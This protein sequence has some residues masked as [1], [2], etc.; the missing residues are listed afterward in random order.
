MRIP[1]ACLLDKD[2]L[3]HRYHG[4]RLLYLLALADALAVSPLFSKLALS[5][6]HGD[7]RRPALSL[8]HKA[9]KLRVNLLPSVSAA[10]FKLLKLAPDR[11]CLRS[12]VLSKK[13]S[14]EGAPAVQQAAT[15]VYN[16]GVLA[17]ALRDAHSASLARVLATLQLRD[18]GLLLR[19]W[20][21]RHL[22]HNAHSAAL[23]DALW[24]A[25][26]HC[27]ETACVVR[28]GRVAAA[29]LVLVSLTPHHL[30]AP[31]RR[32]P[33]CTRCRPSAPC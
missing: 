32:R 15:P 31:F 5:T 3:N 9:T 29:R 20:S 21:H 33:R 16:A 4:K 26:A 18:V 17:D 11:N 2:H 22:P 19:L 30:I 6:P 12:A 24:A 1:D 7:L 25:L 8:T 28:A 14:A 13:R 10:L 27:V 23:L